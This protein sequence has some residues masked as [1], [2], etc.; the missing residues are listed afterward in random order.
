MDDLTNSMTNAAA[1]ASGFG[2]GKRHV[3]MPHEQ[4]TQVTGAPPLLK[5]PQLG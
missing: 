3:P 2:M 4:G 1:S 5:T